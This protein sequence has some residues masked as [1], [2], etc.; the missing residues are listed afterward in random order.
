MFLHLG[1]GWGEGDDELPLIQS[2][3]YFYELPLITGVEYVGTKINVLLILLV[4]ESKVYVI[5]EAKINQYLL[6]DNRTKL[7]E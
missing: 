7:V 6:D 5:V 2:V 1:W 4:G 3:E